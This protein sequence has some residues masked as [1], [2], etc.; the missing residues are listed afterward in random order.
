MKEREKFVLDQIRQI[1]ELHRS[2]NQQI[3]IKNILDRAKDM[4]KKA[5][6]ENPSQQD[7]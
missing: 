1:K 7:R 5:N 4:L 6:T 3:G 2:Y